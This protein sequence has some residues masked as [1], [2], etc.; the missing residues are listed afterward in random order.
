MLYHQGEQNEHIE[1]YQLTQLPR[2][3]IQSSKGK[4]D[5]M[6]TCVWTTLCLNKAKNK[7][8]IK[9]HFISSIYEVWIGSSSCEILSGF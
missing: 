3:I 8:C 6:S 7:N 5:N 1:T 9:F 4:E 2:K